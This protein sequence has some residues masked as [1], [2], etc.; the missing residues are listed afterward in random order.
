MAIFTRPSEIS[1]LVTRFIPLSG[2]PRICYS[3]AGAAGQVIS[4]QLNFIDSFKAFRL[5]RIPLA[6]NVNDV[7][8]EVIWT[9]QLPWGKSEGYCLAHTRALFPRLNQIV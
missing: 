7:M 2:V 6:N 9:S 3:L 8:Y 1:W 4:M 5:T